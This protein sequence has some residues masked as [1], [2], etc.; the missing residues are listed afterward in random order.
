MNFEIVFAREKENREGKKWRKVREECE[1]GD[2]SVQK[3]KVKLKLRTM[4]V[5]SILFNYYVVF[6]LPNI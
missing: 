1:R 4:K 3:F 2:G 6:L 5:A